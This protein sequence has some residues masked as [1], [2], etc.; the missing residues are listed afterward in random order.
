M[1]RLLQ[2]IAVALL[3]LALLG[4]GPL[5]FLLTKTFQLFQPP[6]KT[7]P[8]YSL[9]GKSA[10]ILVDPANQDLSE[11]SPQV[12]YSIAKALAAELSARRAAG[13]IVSP[14]D[15]VTYAQS[16]AD[17]NRKSAVEIGRDFSVDL[18]LHVVI[19]T[20][21]LDTAAGADSYN[22][23]VELGLRVIDVAAGQQVF[24]DMGQLHLVG[25]RSPAGIAAEDAVKARKILLDGLVLKTGQ[26]F[27][28]Y[29]IEE[30]PRKAQ[31]R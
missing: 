17:Y 12:A 11:R 29:L 13:S 7:K 18:V 20:Y 9:A 19:Q 28:P 8:L 16:E 23:A 1:K 21:H 14:R 4:C 30:L 26:V 5:D 15:V 25:V 22:G 3:S 6:P 10:L 2:I 27:V 31:V 24:P